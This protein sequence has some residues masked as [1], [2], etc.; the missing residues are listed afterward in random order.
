MKTLET[1]LP[2][3]QVGAFSLPILT[4]NSNPPASVQQT[5]CGFTFFPAP[6]FSGSCRSP[7]AYLCPQLPISIGTLCEETRDDDWKLGRQ[8]LLSLL[9]SNYNV[10]SLKLCSRPFV[11]ERGSMQ[12][13]ATCPDFLPPLD[14]FSFSPSTHFQT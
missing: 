9:S 10:P 7:I 5:T 3:N 6:I 1:H 8:C 13:I 12:I 14:N 2:G 4:S 11:T